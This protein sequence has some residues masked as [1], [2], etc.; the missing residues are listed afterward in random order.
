MRWYE[1]LALNAFKYGGKVPKSVAF[2]MD[3]NRRFAIDKLKKEKS[4]GHRHGME[5]M[6]RVIEWC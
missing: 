5:R 4:E 1:K 3:G 6:I 2:I